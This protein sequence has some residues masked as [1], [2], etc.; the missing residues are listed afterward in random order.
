M[1]NSDLI[2][3]LVEIILQQE[4]DLNQVALDQVKTDNKPNDQT[5][6]EV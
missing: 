1:N 3:R 6:N 4:K 2:W 5:Q